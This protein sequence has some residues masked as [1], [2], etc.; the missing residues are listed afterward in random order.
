MQ[1]LAARQ[2]SLRNRLII[3]VSLMLVPLLAIAGGS[4]F[5]F[6]QAVANF[7]INEN[8]RLEELFPLA[9]L[10]KSLL[11][12]SDLVENVTPYNRAQRHDSFM[13]LS[14]D[15]Q[16]VFRSLLNAPSQLTE[17][18][19]LVLGIQSEWNQANGMGQAFLMRSAALDPT[20]IQQQAIIKQHL[21]KAINAS[22]RLN[23]LLAHFQTEDNLTRAQAFKQRTRAII[24]ASAI[25]AASLAILSGLVLAR[26]ILKPLKL[27]SS[28]VAKF[29]DGDLSYR[30]QITTKDELEQLA[31]SINWMAQKLEQSQQKL[32]ELA[33]I[34]GLTGVFNR[35][36]FNRRLTVELERSR[37]ENHP[38]SLLMVDID[39]F[40]KLNDTYGHQAG[41][42]ALRVVSKLIKT[43]VRPGDL[44]ARYGGEEFA[45]ILPYAD[46]DDA[47]AVAERLRS[48]LAELDI[49]I[50]DGKTIQVTASLGCATFPQDAQTEELLMAA[51]DGA[52]Y[53][54]KNNGRNR[55]CVA[56]KIL[57]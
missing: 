25:I 23:D 47:F 32:L 39:H 54:A 13:S 31:N 57:V 51:A 33:T 44:P 10:E 16:G 42:D 1:K 36:E 38:V 21:D 41:D 19:S 55:V 5:F 45:V 28:G 8:K 4:Y 9:E 29:G 3:G 17:K 7:E 2:T 56:S 50:Q 12:A 24:F 52:L 35:R 22:R 26:S 49:P 46:S 43:E 18:R 30:I 37:R 27:L 20:A 48:L 11:Q 15:I 40:K 53:Q 14:Q 34:D 6:E